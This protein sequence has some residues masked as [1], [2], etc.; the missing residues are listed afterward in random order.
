MIAYVIAFVATAIV[1]LGIDVIWL[2]YIAKDFYA[3]HMGELM[4]DDPKLG[5]AAI[6]YLFYVLGIIYL[7]IA[8]HMES[9]NWKAV[10]ISGAVLGALAYGTYDMTNYAV[11]KGYPL[12]VAIVDIAWGT[13]LTA[14]AS[15]AGFFATK[16]FG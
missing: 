16:L 13:A 2:K 4:R 10:L 12:K 5:A 9:G 14:T 3:T 1:F 8:P 6:F 7:V 15:L 11:L